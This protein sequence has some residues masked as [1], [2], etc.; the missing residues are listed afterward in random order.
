MNAS[1]MDSDGRYWR[2]DQWFPN[3]SEEIRAALKAYHTELLFFNSRINLISPRTEK[4]ADLVH[5]ADG[6]LGSQAVLERTAAQEIF[7]IGSGNGIPGIVLAL[8]DSKRSVVLIDS[9]SRKIEFMKHCVS[10]LDLPNC[11]VFHARFEE[12]PESSIKCAVSRGF[13]SISKTLLLGRKVTAPKCEFYHFKG[14]AWSSEIAAIP[15]QIMAHWEPLHTCDYPLPLG[16]S[17]MSIVLTKKVK[18]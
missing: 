16:E 9:D 12:M 10:R 15:S 6:I 13:A 7:D 2:I 17:V 18:K 5:V 1:E 4:I 14:P 11:R 3:L 8:L